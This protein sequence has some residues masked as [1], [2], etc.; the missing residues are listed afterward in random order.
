MNW[1]VLVPEPETFCPS[2]AQFAGRGLPLGSKMFGTVCL[3]V[4]KQ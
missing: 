1:V 2:G 4:S 3:F